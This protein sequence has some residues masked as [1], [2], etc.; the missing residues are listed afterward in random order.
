[1]TGLARFH[2]AQKGIFP[3]TLAELQ[4]GRKKTHWM[5]FVFPQHVSLGRSEMAKRYGIADIAEAQ[6]YLSDPVLG[7]RLKRCT[8]AVLSHRDTP[9]DDILGEVDAMK[10]RSCLTLFL[11]ADPD[12]PVFAEALETFYAGNPDPLTL[13]ALKSA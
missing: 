10:F 4:S 1:M 7:P 8:D 11:A 3:T 12:E 2:D 5:W 13:A 6:A 9:I